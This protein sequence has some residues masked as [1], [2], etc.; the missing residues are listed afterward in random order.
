MRDREVVF[1]TSFVKVSEVDAD[2]NLSVL[3][4]N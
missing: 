2:S 1:D 4:F 3:L